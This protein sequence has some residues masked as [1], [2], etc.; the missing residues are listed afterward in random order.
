MALCVRKE[1]D[2]KTSITRALHNK[3]P[4]R[5]NIL[6][7]GLVK[8]TPCAHIFQKLFSFGFYFDRQIIQPSPVNAIF[9]TYKNGFF[10]GESKNLLITSFVFPSASL[11]V[12]RT[13]NRAN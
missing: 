11:T 3:M 10:V 12:S 13:K 8:G 1:S 5:K 9:L 7:N 6:R 4:A 2:R